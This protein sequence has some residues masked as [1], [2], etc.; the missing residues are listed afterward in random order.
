MAAMPN[1][2]LRKYIGRWMICLGLGLLTLMLIDV[3]DGVVAS[4]R[5]FVVVAN[6]LCV[7]PSYVIGTCRDQ[8]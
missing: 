6:W 1:F 5:I 3:G 2:S 8:A 7:V 4:G